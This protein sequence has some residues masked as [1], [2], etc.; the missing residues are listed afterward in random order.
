MWSSYNHPMLGCRFRSLFALAL[1]LTSRHGPLTGR[2]SPRRPR[3]RARGPEPGRRSAPGLDGERIGRPHLDREAVDERPEAHETRR[4]GSPDRARRPVSMSS[5]T[6]S[7]ASGASQ[8]SST[9]TTVARLGSSD[10]CAGLFDAQH[11]GEGSAGPGVCLGAHTIAKRLRQEGGDDQGRR[12]RTGGGQLSPQSFV[13]GA[14]PRPLGRPRRRSSRRARRPVRRGRDRRRDRQ[15][16][17]RS[18]RSR[19]R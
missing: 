13:P 12:R 2:S 5:L 1:T 17:P 14:R 19:R 15:G 3:E 18:E 6:S 8:R 10:G 9:S 11:P 7:H 16:A 4:R